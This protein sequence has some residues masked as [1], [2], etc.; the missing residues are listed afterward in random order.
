MSSRR[1]S[2]SAGKTGLNINTKKTQGLRVNTINTDPILID[3]KPI[4]DVDAFTYLGN[5][6][7][8]TGDCKREIDTRISQANQAFVMLKPIWR[9][10]ALNIHTKIRIFNSNVLGVLLTYVV[11]RGWKTSLVI[12]RKLGA[13]QTKSVR[14]IPNIF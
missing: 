11:Q 2:L 6:I 12:D 7:I 10:I 1:Q 3:S 5:K 8:I 14:C 13:F 4:E 9:S